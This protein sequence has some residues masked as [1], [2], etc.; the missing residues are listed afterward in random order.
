MFHMPIQAPKCL[1]FAA[2][3]VPVFCLSP[4]N[5]PGPIIMGL[6]FDSSCLVWQ[7]RCDVTGAC[8]VYDPQ[9][10]SA[11][12]FIAATAVKAISCL[13]F[14][15][16]ALLHKPPPGSSDYLAQQKEEA[17]KEEKAYPDDYEDIPSVPH[18][19]HFTRLWAVGDRTAI[20]F[21]ISTENKQRRLF[22]CLK[23]FTPVTRVHPPCPTLYRL[24]SSWW[25]HNHSLVT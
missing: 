3:I 11:G 2:Q 14:G 7:S 5:V 16:A 17:A 10:L 22:G 6:I 21:K 13:C 25:L 20:L 19:I 4:G 24:V 15:L 12:M 18:I 8:W 9:Y 23:G 1:I